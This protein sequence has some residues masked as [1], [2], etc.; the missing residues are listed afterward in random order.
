MS[1]SPRLFWGP[2][3]SGFFFPE[4]WIADRLGCPVR[5]SCGSAV[6]PRPFSGSALEGGPSPCASSGGCGWPWL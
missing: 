3:D 6:H 2:A 1:R 5:G 4:L